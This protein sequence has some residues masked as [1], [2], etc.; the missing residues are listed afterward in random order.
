MSDI[1]PGALSMEE[2]KRR[3][4][5]IGVNLG[6][7]RGTTMVGGKKISSV[8]DAYLLSFS[9]DPELVARKF[10]HFVVEIKHPARFSRRVGQS[11]YEAGTPNRTVLNRVKYAPREY[12]V[13]ADAP[14]AIAFVK[15]EQF[16][17]DREI[18][19][20]CEPPDVRAPLDRKLVS[21]VWAGNLCKRIS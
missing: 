19:I 21:A 14:A 20:V 12:D 4:A 15:P 6:N 1:G 7:A 17:E 11:L 18:R 9:E 8:T 5:K 13:T 3:A 2:L 10:G 16:A